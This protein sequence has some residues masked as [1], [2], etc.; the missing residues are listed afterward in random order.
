M[1]EIYYSKTLNF[2]EKNINTY[3]LQIAFEFNNDITRARV[4]QTLNPFLSSVKNANGLIDYRVTCNSSNNPATVIED[5]QL[6]VDIE[7]KLVHCAKV[8][9]INYILT[10]TSASFTSN[11]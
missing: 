10:K 9:T 11:A 1:S 8:I 5:N 6:I 2:L 4:V 7:L 3:M